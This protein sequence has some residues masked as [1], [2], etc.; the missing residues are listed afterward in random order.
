LKRAILGGVGQHM[1]LRGTLAD[2]MDPDLLH[3]E[4]ETQACRVPFV[5]GEPVEM[6]AV[7]WPV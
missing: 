4:E 5:E 7:G 3:Q 2:V 1:K 6:H